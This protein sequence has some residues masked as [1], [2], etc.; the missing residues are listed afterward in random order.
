MNLLHHLS[1]LE[2]S[3]LIILAQLQPEIEYLFRHALVQEAAY[4]SLVRPDRRL[5]HQ[6]VGQAL[7]RL[8]PGRLESLELAPLLARHFAEAGDLARALH[9]YTRAA[10]GA[11][12]MYANA[13]AI[14]LFT[15]ALEL[16]QAQRAGGPTIIDLFLRRGK[17]YELNAQDAE[18]IANYEALEAWGV[19]AGDRAAQLAALAACATIYVKPSVQQNHA[20][21]YELSQQ[22]LALARDLGDPASE[23]KVLW[24]LLLYY[25][26]VGDSAGAQAAG[27]Q[28][29][30]IARAHNLR[31]Q[32]AYVLTDLLKLYYQIEQPERAEAALHEA[33]SLWRELGVLNMLA[34]NLASTSMMR[35]ISG[36][37]EQAL[38]LSQEAE[39]IGRQIGNMWNEAYSHYLVEVIYFERGD[40]AQAIASAETCRRLS[41]QAGFAEGVH[42]SQFS[43]A[44]IYGEM[45]ALPRAWEAAQTLLK[46]VNP[47]EGQSPYLPQL[48]ALK[49]LLQLRAGQWAEAQAALDESG[50]NRDPEA[51]QRQFV[52]TQLVYALAKG[53]LAL[54]LGRPSEALALVETISRKLRQSNVRIFYV[55][56]LLLQ[57]QALRADGRLLEAQAMLH[58]A[59]AE[60]EAL[61]SRR[62][63]WAVLVELAA[64]AAARGDHP[65]DQALLNQSAEIINYIAAHAGE[66]ALAESFLSRAPV[67]A[68]LERAGRLASG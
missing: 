7:E 39:R 21:G 12:A 24:N 18:A 51:L 2:S 22:A 27:E 4:S 58:A 13:E 57:G 26:A 29:L 8:H 63:L 17:A 15:Q 19:A 59:R 25:L 50:L 34:D 41:A 47:L 3:G 61:G 43:L 20:R 31:E 49:A 1:A 64:L 11:A 16:A 48:A 6:A 46:Q 54:A 28:A 55:D 52:I 37:Y 32:V 38:A 10:R 66:P 42:Q 68:V 33:A 14:L 35:I 5:L 23:A 60:A 45:G 56:T 9:Y 36:N 40:I 65:A 67:R 30:A 62:T 44:I 53:E